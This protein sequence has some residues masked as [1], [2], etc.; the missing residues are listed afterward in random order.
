MSEQLDKFECELPENYSRSTIDSLGLNVCFS[1]GGAVEIYK[2][3]NLVGWISLNYEYE[4]VFEGE[5]LI[6]IK[7][8]HS[9]YKLNDFETIEDNKKIVKAEGLLNPYYY[10]FTSNE[11]DNYRFAFVCEGKDEPVYALILKSEECSNEEFMEVVNNTT[12][13]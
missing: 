2:G 1:C 3:E 9:W 10:D 12:V 11:T 4:P 13:E 7:G 6:S 5:Q 8:I